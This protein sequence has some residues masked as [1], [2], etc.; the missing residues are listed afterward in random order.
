MP[1]L[2]E[3]ETTRRGIRPHLKDQ[4]VSS[5]AIHNKQLRWPIPKKLKSMLQGKIVREVSRR[6][7]YLLLSLDHGTVLVHLGM[8]GH[9][10]IVTPNEPVK[11]HDHVV[12]TINE[13][14]SLRYN[15]P[16]RFGAW[17]WTD[18]PVAEH[19][20]LAKLGPEPLTHAFNVAYLQKTIAKRKAPVKQV[21]MDSKVVVGVGN[22]YANEALFEAG[23]APR[24]PVH[25]VSEKQL[26]RLVKAIKS[27]LKTAIK[28]GGTTL[29][30]FTQSD[31][32]PGYF[33]QQL[34]V[35]GRSG[36]PCVNCET[37]LTEIRLGQRSTVFCPQ[38]Q[39][40]I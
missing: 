19:P 15:D 25:L 20:L 26:T 36:L 31:G 32:K 3:V 16:R 5:V 10:K 7:K 2:P 28:Q 24:E 33:A 13:N 22:I 18:K 27:I 14:K 11:K 6:G 30:D 21:I 39:Q 38:C 40:G 29:K 23:I 8:S 12:L 1:E 17:L 37:E 4:C 35:Y 34:K 9:I